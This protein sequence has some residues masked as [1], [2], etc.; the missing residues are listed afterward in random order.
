MPCFAPLAAYRP[1]GGGSLEFT[2]RPG[3]QPLEIS[4]GQCIGCR[5][6]RSRQW[7]VRCMHEAQLH[8]DNEFVT[9]TYDDDHIPADHS[10]RYSDFQLFMKRLRTHYGERQRIRFYMCGE[11]GE[12]TS[13]PHYHA[14]LFGC[15]FPDRQLFTVT[16]AGEKIYTSEIL[17]K[18][19][20]LGHASTGEVTFESA[21]YVARYVL[22]KRFG[23]VA[24]EHSHY[25][26]V[27]DYGEVHYRMPEFNHM[28]LKPGIGGDW[29]DKY[30]DSV[31]PRDRVVVR[32]V[33]VKPPK[34]YVRLLEK[35]DMAMREYLDYTRY[36]ESF[37]FVND[38]T[39]SRLRVRE[40]CARARLKSKV[41]RLE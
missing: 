32:G 25:K 11:Y 29:F 30:A 16:G 23:D 14:C 4:C 35:R 9:L 26:F 20:Q 6:E 37:S 27:D 40:H 2:E 24:N 17:S 8:E 10:L 28:S 7:A 41:R 22:K 39:P 1:A 31:F 33:E 5:L 12:N 15:G 19:W 18:C 13:R 21:A 3:S 38:S 34:Y 36:R